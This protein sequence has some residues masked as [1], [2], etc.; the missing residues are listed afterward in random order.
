MRANIF[1]AHGKAVES[2]DVKKIAE[3]ERN[4]AIARLKNAKHFHVITIGEDGRVGV[5]SA[6]HSITASVKT[7]IA[8]RESSKIIVNE[9][10][11]GSNNDL[12]DIGDI[13]GN[14]K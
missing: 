13:E 6:L 1:S 2:I 12:E 3:G 14:K 8:F 11:K 5:V 7:M 10:M 4:K 9:L